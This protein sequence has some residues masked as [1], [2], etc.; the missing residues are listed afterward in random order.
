MKA[1]RPLVPAR[2][3]VTR[4]RHTETPASPPSR[5]QPNPKLWGWLRPWGRFVNTDLLSP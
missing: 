5:I 4:R 3:E 1:K 2:T